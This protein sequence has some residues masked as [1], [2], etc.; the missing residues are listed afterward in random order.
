MLQVVH[1][2]RI[3]QDAALY[4]SFVGKPVVIP[5]QY[6]AHRAVFANPGA[7]SKPILL[8]SYGAPDA[9]P[10]P[11][12]ETPYFA[13]SVAVKMVDGKAEV[14][15]TI[16]RSDNPAEKRYTSTVTP[17]TA[18]RA[19]LTAAMTD[20]P[21][22]KD[23][24]VNP[25]DSAGRLQVRSGVRLYGLHLQEVQDA[26]KALP[27]GQAAFEAAGA[28]LHG[29]ESDASPPLSQPTETSAKASRK[30]NAAPAATV[31]VMGDDA[32]VSS[33]PAA[34]TAAT[35]ATPNGK[36]GVRQQRRAKAE[37][38]EVHTQEDSSTAP[39]PAKRRR[40]SAKKAEDGASAT[41]KA[42]A[43]PAKPAAAVVCPDCGLAGTPFC[44]ATGKPH[45]VP[46]CAAC[47]LRTAFCPVSGQPHAGAAQ[48]ENRQRGEVHLPGTARKPSRRKS[49]A[50]AAAA[51]GEAAAEVT[52]VST[53]EEGGEAVAANA[54]G[55]TR[56]KRGQAPTVD[57]AADDNGAAVEATAR[58][59]RGR[60]TKKGETEN[61]DAT[62]AT[63]PA[64]TAEDEKQKED[65]AAA[66]VPVV[67]AGDIPLLE[68]V[69]E[70]IYIY[71][72]LRPP[73]VAKDH[74][75]AA[76]LLQEGWKAQYGDG[77]VLPPA[78][79]AVPLAFVP[80]KRATAAA[81]R[82]GR[83]AAGG[84]G[85]VEAVKE[86]EGEEKPHD[87]DGELAA[88][89]GQAE[90]AGEHQKE[91]TE[92]PMSWEGSPTTADAAATLPAAQPS[93]VHPLEV[94]QIAT[95]AAG[96]RLAK[97]L[98][99]YTSERSQLDLLRNHAAS[100]TATT[101]DGSVKRRGK[102]AKEPED[103][104][105]EEG[106]VSS[107]QPPKQQ[108]VEKMETEDGSTDAAATAAVAAAQSEEEAEAK[109]AETEEKSDEAGDAAVEVGEFAENEGEAQ[110]M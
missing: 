49:A 91:T 44:A 89:E 55:K 34:D 36:K 32:V 31:V 72:P 20:F 81:G 76:Q 64:K 70:S 85:G 86:E 62:A 14:T 51:S 53:Q 78:V 40:A 2:G 10:P 33:Q 68:A 82:R 61:A 71:P 105:E 19:A 1:L 79:A 99:Q 67:D 80:A 41:S 16:T 94:T 56:K 75:R 7:A 37:V 43:S 9:A 42:A 60:K 6:V 11:A 66:A 38:V 69:K 50:A 21:D 57:A 95:S 47:G 39:P 25:P 108:R 58:P 109:V 29:V 98:L 30:R 106:G 52:V 54:G 83:K 48:R 96:K 110:E 84:G 73:L 90:D 102:K 46:P 59:R 107:S 17:T 26:L 65:N 3:V 35:A 12:M 18:W 63:A 13:A 5:D 101:G 100:A 74:H 23:Q 97:F 87:N 103:G 4:S 24:L 27:N 77:P 92:D 8:S 22:R 45:E 93:M 88:A 104:A 28:A 15:Y